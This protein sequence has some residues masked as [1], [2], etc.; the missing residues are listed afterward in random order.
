MAVNHL[1][2]V[3][4]GKALRNGELGHGERAGAVSGPV[5][6]L[7]MGRSGSTLL[8]VI[9][10][11]HP[12]LACP[13]E[14][15]MPALLT[16]LPTLWSIAHGSPSLKSAEALPEATLAGIRQTLDAAITTYLRRVGKRVF[17][18]KSLGTAQHAELV[19]QVYPDAKF[20]CLFRHP[21]DVI[22]SAIEACP[23]GLSG[24]GFEPYAA[25]S[26]TNMVAAIANY[27]LDHA[28]AIQAAARKYPSDSICVRYEDLVEAP[29]P[30]ISRLFEFLGVSA[31]PGI[32]TRCLTEP[33]DTLGHAD[34]KIWGTSEIT[35]ASV[36]RGRSLPWD[37]VHPK[38]RT[39]MNALLAELG[40]LPVD[41]GW[42]A[43]GMPWDPREPGSAQPAQRHDTAGGEPPR[44]DAGTDLLGSRL[45]AAAGKLDSEFRQRWQAACTGL[46]AVVSRPDSGEEDTCWVLDFP[47]GTVE[48]RPAGP[49]DPHEWSVV[50]SP[51]VWESVLTGAV[52]LGVAFSDG[53]IRIHTRK[54]Y[55]RLERKLRQAMIADLLGMPIQP[56]PVTSQQRQP[57]TPP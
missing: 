3:L 9:L 25:A 34:Y 1:D 18:D 43:P 44:Q 54:T 22:K 41:E 53:Q 55:Y 46:V 35:T 11:T 45:R 7:T 33:H 14:T 52:P 16:H 30:V 12:E 31:Q 17:C 42:G 10:D 32:S 13:P 36:G 23:F 40:Y 21:M 5:F 28:T 4:N 37:S 27:W 6:V 8:R 49:A 38:L 15:M 51:Q 19:R 56:Q 50:G 39:P 26:P 2:G 24:H 47:H 57:V 48:Q 29:E 20:I